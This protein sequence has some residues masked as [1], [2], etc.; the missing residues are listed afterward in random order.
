MN[1]KQVTVIAR[2]RAQPGKEADV[3]KELISL[4]SPSRKDPG[5][6]N[7][8]LHRSQADPASFLFHENWESRELL[9]RHLAKTELQATIARVTALV[10]EPPEISVWDKIG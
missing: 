1:R 2:V 5:C 4:I 7:Y 8:D 6:I 3:L 9:D 10:A